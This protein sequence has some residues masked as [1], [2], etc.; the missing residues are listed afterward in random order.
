MITEPL[1]PQLV[2]VHGMVFVRRRKNR[3]LRWLL[4]PWHARIRRYFIKAF[5]ESDAR[6]GTKG[7]SYN[8]GGLL[9][10]D[11]ELVRYFAWLASVPGNAGTAC[12]LAH[13][14]TAR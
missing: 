5:L 14:T 10:G 12:G 11:D 2:Q 6:M 8:P 7:L 9:E 13:D 4:D 3:I 1:G